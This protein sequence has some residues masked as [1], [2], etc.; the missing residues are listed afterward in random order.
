MADDIHLMSGSDD[1]TVRIWD[2]ASQSEV[3]KYSDS[4]VSAICILGLFG[5]P[6]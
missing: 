6:Y 2:I 4:T 5:L 3:S 1:K